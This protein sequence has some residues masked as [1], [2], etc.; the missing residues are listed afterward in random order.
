MRRCIRLCLDCVDVCDATA[1]LLSR[2]T[3]YVPKPLA[4]GG[5]LL[6]LCAICAAECER[7]AD[8]HEHCRLCGRSAGACEQ[9]CPTAPRRSGLRPKPLAISTA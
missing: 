7:H 8:H 2:Q 6:E 5:V 9:A 1:R 3:D 4:A